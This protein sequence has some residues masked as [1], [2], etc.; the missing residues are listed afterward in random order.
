MALS[1][2]GIILYNEC[3]ILSPHD[4]SWTNIQ[5]SADAAAFIEAYD[6]DHLSPSERYYMKQKLADNCPFTV[7]VFVPEVRW[8]THRK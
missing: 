4:A 6:G 1:R 7:T 3:C 2:K 5:L 8:Q